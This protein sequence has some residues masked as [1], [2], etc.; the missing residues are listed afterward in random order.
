MPPKTLPEVDRFTGWPRAALQFFAGL[1]R[2]NSKTYFD[3]H[4]GVY[5]TSVREPMAALMATLEREL[6]PGWRT[7]IFRINRD[8][9]FSPD[10]R[11]Y[12]EHAGAYLSGTGATGF[13]VQ[14][15]HEGLYLAAGIHEMAPDQL[16]RY[17]EAIVGKA[18]EK[19]TRIVAKVVKDGYQVSEPSL[20]RVPA[21]YPKDHPR[22]ELLRR[23]SAMASRTWRPG[24]WLHA[25]EALMQ[26]RQ[27]WRDAQPLTA[28]VEAQVG[29]STAPSRF[30]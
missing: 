12:K 7:K 8:L 25:P 22:A 26:V 23:T 27:G 5:D 2:D 29:P 9:R 4:R 10:K 3:A 6:G 30:R 28:W 13:Y 20:K 1:R 16:T 19:L 15:S 17:R 18:G 14:L 11:P 24:P 21:G